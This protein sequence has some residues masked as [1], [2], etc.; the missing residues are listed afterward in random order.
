MAKSISRTWFLLLPVVLLVLAHPV[1]SAWG[2]QTIKL[3]MLIDLSGPAGEMG[4]TV[5]DVAQMAVETVNGAGGI[6]GREIELTTFD[7]QGDATLGNRGARELVYFRNVT[8]VLGPTDWATAMVAKPFL[9]GAQVPTMML[10]W[11]DSVIRGGKFGMYEWVFRLPVR[12]KTALAR[13]VAFLK[14]KGWLRVGLVSGVDSLG[15]EARELFAN[16]S[17]EHGIRIV[18]EEPFIPTENMIAKLRTLANGNPQV[19][20]CL[21]P[22]PQSTTMATFLREMGV[23]LPIFLW[24]ETPPHRYVETAGPAATGSLLV[25]NKMLVWEDLENDDPQKGLIRDFYGRLGREHGDTQGQPINPFFAYVWDSIMVLARSM[26]EAGIDRAQLRDG[27]E[28]TYRHVG[29]GGIY[30]FTHEDHNGL[31]ADSIVV[32]KVDRVTGGSGGWKGSWRLAE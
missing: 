11:E 30:G 6:A 29:L 1:W 15:R 22:F 26:Q 14:M 28:S 17:A 2:K 32:G 27:I 25:S 9:E 8:A 5:T 20:V 16:L 3:G 23:N 18:G 4:K 13:M 19:F 24:H 12:R 31:D 7:T 21:C 10:T